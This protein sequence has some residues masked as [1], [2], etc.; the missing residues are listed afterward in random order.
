MSKSF[1]QQCL[2]MIGQL[3]KFV[4]GINMLE[5]NGLQVLNIGILTDCDGM[6]ISLTQINANVSKVASC[7]GANIELLFQRVDN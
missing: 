5:L 2:F 3:A 4:R 1:A 6:V 7:F